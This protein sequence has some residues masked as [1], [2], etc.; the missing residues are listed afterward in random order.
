MAGISLRLR[1]GLELL[2]YIALTGSEFVL[3]S[4][5]VIRG[6]RMGKK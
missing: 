2:L 3:R 6:L 5:L 1:Y 4:Y